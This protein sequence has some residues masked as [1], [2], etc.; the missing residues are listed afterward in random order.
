MRFRTATHRLLAASGAIQ[1]GDGVI[2][3]FIPAVS[4]SPTISVGDQSILEGADGTGVLR[5]Q[6]TL[7]TPATGSTVAVNYAVTGDTATGA[8]TAGANVDFKTRTGVLKFVP[9]RTGFTPA[10]RTVAVTVYGDPTVEA[11]ETPHLTLSNPSGPYVI[12]R[13]VGTGVILND[14]GIAPGTTL[15]LGDTSIRNA[16]IGSQKLSI[17]LTLSTAPTQ[18]LVVNYTITPGSAFFAKGVTGRP[19]KRV[20]RA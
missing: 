3:I 16:T 11:D 10:S 8:A 18:D 9:Q 19:S 4:A 2:R 12:G 13:G 17:P 1:R 5:F 15:G 14:D 6:V 7:S 20:D